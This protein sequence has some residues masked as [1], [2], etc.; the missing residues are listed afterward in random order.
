MGFPVQTDAPLMDG[1]IHCA[2]SK[3]FEIEATSQT[4][5]FRSC[6][7][8][9]LS[10]RDKAIRRKCGSRRWDGDL[11]GIVRASGGE[12]VFPLVIAARSAGAP[13]DSRN[14]L[15]HRVFARRPKNYLPRSPSRVT[16]VLSVPRATR[17]ALGSVACSPTRKDLPCSAPS[18]AAS[19]ASRPVASA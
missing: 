14:P 18:L 7:S 19:L 1:L 8:V 16:F 13:S 15:P 12:N 6:A 2:I 3:I 17:T 5:R 9:R 10:S 4:R 11:V